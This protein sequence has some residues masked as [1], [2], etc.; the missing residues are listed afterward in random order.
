MIRPA[1]PTR[2]VPVIAI[3]GVLILALVAFLS[4]RARFAF[5]QRRHLEAAAEVLAAPDVVTRVLPPTAAGRAQGISGTLRFRPRGRLSVL[6]FRG[7]PPVVGHERYLVFLQNY[8]GWLLAGAA[9]PDANGNAEIRFAA[10][11]RPITIYEVVAIEFLKCLFYILSGHICFHVALS[12]WAN[13]GKI[14]FV[15]N[16]GNFLSFSGKSEVF[17]RALLL[18]RTQ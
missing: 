5:D 15:S 12:T 18:G 10:E 3:A 7:L 8:G 6:T 13:R 4:V 17:I 9:L 14:V 11:P 16:M 1:R 2:S